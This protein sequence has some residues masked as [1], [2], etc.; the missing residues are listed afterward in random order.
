MIDRRGIERTVQR[1]RH[2]VIALRPVFAAHVLHHA[3][4]SALD[5]HFDSIVVAIQNRHRS[6]NSAHG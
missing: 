5:N 4:V 1:T 2:Y 3:N 6:V